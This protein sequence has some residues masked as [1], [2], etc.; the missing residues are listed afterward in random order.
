MAKCGA[1]TKTGRRCQRQVVTNTGRC[2]IHQGPLT[3]YGVKQRK[4]KEAR[5][6]MQKIRGRRKKR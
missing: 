1:P 4:A 5:A 2:P 3:S 6:K